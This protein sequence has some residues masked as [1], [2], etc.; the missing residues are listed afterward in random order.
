MEPIYQQSLQITNV[1]LIL[2]FLPLIMGIKM[3]IVALRAEV[4][5]GIHLP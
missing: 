3:T 4:V 2:F 5:V 1:P